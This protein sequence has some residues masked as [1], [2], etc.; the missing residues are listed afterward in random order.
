MNHE[1]IQAH[2][3]QIKRAYAK[4]E[5]LPLNVAVALLAEVRRQ[6]A[7]LYDFEDGH[8]YTKVRRE[9][10]YWAGHYENDKFEIKN[11]VAELFAVKAEAARLREELAA[12]R[13][14]VA[15]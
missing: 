9:R 7:R 8:A 11:L 12:A 3:D 2:D 13:G 4:D 5:P 14:G 1:Q 6:S 10:D 15:A